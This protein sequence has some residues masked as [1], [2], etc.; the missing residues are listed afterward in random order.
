MRGSFDAVV[1][2]EGAAA[3]QSG[4]TEGHPALRAF[5][6]ERMAQRGIQC[7]PEQILVTTGS[8]QALD[9]LGKALLPRDAT[10]MV[11][12]PSY[13][14]ALNAFM[15]AEPRYLPV[16]LDDQGL[17]VDL[18]ANALAASPSRV[19]LL[20]TVATFQNP[21]GCTLSLDRRTALLALC[22]THGL[23]L[24]EDDPYGELRYEGP[25]VPA[26]RALPAGDEA[27]DLGSFSKV[28]APG[29]RIGWAV[30]P[31]PLIAR[32]VMAKQAADLHP[33]SLAQPPILPFCRPNDLAAH[34]LQLRAVYCERRDAMLA[35]LA[36]H[37]PAEAHWTVPAG[38]LF[39]WGPL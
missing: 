14:G 35:A 18:A 27:I 12:A 30:A 13:V 10:V 36:R 6:A 16:P 15:L 24:I 17:R 33:D 29:L 38:G 11:E 9:L 1:R 7:Q 34:I 26:L 2:E 37:F 31:R 21:S 8:Q 32:L 20:Y 5:L 19:S 4:P 3:L 28:L 25:E 22:A 23:P 39:T